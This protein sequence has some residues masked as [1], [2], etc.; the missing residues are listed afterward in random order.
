MAKDPVS[1]AIENVVASYWQ[2]MQPLPFELRACLVGGLLAK[3]LASAPEKKQHK[4]ALDIL[5]LAGELLREEKR[6][7]Q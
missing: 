4:L 2:E 3:V 5:N 6:P 7:G 1:T